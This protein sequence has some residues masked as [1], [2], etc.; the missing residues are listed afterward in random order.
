MLFIAALGIV[1]DIFKLPISPLILAFILGPMLE[2]NL[3]KGLTYTNQGF[4]VFLT[5]PVSAAFLL[6]ALLSLI[7]P[8][9]KKRTT[10]KK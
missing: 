4:S 7:V 1:M 9:L 5:R 3:R 8:E 2:T 6:I 10:N